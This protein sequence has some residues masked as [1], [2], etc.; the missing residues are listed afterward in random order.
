M[1]N[2]TMN[3]EFK[4]VIDRVTQLLENN[5]D[6]WEKRYD[7]YIE[8]LNNT[9][10]CDNIKN[11]SGKFRLP[12]NLQRYIPITML[13]KSSKGLDVFFDLRYLGKS[14]A[15]VNVYQNEGIKFG[16]KRKCRDFKF[17]ANELFTPDQCI[18]DDQHSNCWYNKNHKT[19]TKFKHL[20][21]SG[22]KGIKNNEAKF[23][24]LLLKAMKSES[25]NGSNF[26]GINITPIKVADVGFFQMPTAVSASHVKDGVEAITY[27]SS[28]S[29]GG[30]IDIMARMNLGRNSRL[31]LFELKDH[32]KE[33]SETPDVVIKQALAYAT[34]IV[35]LIKFKGDSVWKA[36]G[37]N[38]GH[39]TIINVCCLLPNKLDN[40]KEAEIP[41]FAKKQIELDGYTLELH[42]MY[43]DIDKDGNVS[44]ARSSLI[45]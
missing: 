36:F 41:D 25:G 11:A 12:Q 23:E 44:I 32:N 20:F 24:S 8:L 10:V 31:T 6:E 22:A 3:A 9:V 7:E 33:Q 39:S 28:S 17:N 21:K 37:Y 45:K 18:D 2:N 5:K 13:K 14:V 19:V 40:G 26:K 30:G 4:A 29:S 1:E 16:F 42:Y 43:F 27:S 35:K 15:N 38:G 34:F